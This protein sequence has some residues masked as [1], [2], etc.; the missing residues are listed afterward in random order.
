MVSGARCGSLMPSAGQRRGERQ[1][2]H[3][4]HDRLGRRQATPSSQ[5]RWKDCPGRYGPPTTISNRYNRWSRRG[6]WA[7]I[8]EA[9]VF[10]VHEPDELAIDSDV[11]QL[12]GHLLW[13]L[14]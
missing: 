4:A 11:T 6:I 12:V 3:S 2:G 8:F 10:S 5:A 13:G 7:G 9:L 14:V 1:Q